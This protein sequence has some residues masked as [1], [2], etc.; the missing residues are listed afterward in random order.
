MHKIA[1]AMHVLLLCCLLCIFIM[2]INHSKHLLV[3][4]SLTPCKESVSCYSPC[5]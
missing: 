1:Y 2:N 4:D 3:M 5:A